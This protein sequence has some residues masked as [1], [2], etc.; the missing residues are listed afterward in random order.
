MIKKNKKE[1]EFD[2]E[3][4]VKKNK[5]DKKK[6]ILEEAKKITPPGTIHTNLYDAYKNKEVINKFIKE[7]I[8]L[9]NDTE[10]QIKENIVS[11]INKF[12]K[13]F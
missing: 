3:E 7:Y 9:K 4:F 10:D 11:K 6:Y 2:L 12:K 13:I 5:S 8:N 1:K